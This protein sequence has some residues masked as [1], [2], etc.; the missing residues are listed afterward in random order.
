M[1]GVQ[2]ISWG[3]LRPTGCHFGAP[4]KKQVGYPQ[5]P[6][7]QCQHNMYIYNIQYIYRA[8]YRVNKGIDT[9][10]SCLRV[11][12]QYLLGSGES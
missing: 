3:F 11:C 12:V 8:V 4:F 10:G 2:Q 9:V 1:N 6:S 5:R 7:A